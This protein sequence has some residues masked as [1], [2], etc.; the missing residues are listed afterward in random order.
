M[1]RPPGFFFDH[2]SQCLFEVDPVLLFLLRPIMLVVRAPPV[3]KFAL[4]GDRSLGE[5]VKI[6]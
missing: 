5:F 4:N 1:S 6:F 2:L 3:V